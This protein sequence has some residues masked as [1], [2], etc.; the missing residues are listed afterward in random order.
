MKPAMAFT[1][2]SLRL[3]PQEYEFF[4]EAIHNDPR[5]PADYGRWIKRTLEQDACNVSNDEVIQEVLV[6]YSEFAD[7]C[8][9]AGQ[10]P[11]Y[12]MLL[13]LIVARASGLT[14]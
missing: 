14:H 11:C 4:L 6:H 12:D 9:A 5:L 3:L 1:R 2:A 10:Q 7:Y 13:A 8:A